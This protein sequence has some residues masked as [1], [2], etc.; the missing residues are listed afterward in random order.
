MTRIEWP[1]LARTLAWILAAAFVL[2]SVLLL[3]FALE[4]FG[5]PPE[6]GAEFLDNVLADFAWQQTQWPIEFAGTALFAIGFLALGGLGPV[7]GRLARSADARRGIVAAAFLTAGGLGAAS[8][9][10]WIG[11]KPIATS[12]QYCECGLL[13]EELMSRLMTLNIVTGIQTWLVS[14]ALLA[15][16]VGLVAAG[17]LGREAGMPAS[18]EWL[19]LATAVAALMGVVLPLFDVYPFDVLFVVLVAGILVPIWA[20]WLGARAA[21]IWPQAAGERSEPT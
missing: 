18:W 14:G 13:A 15:A 19:A 20:V 7:L 2:A 1:T 3:I 5:G 21:E 8:Q 4:L 10:L 12:A 9:L 17:R 11:A 6:P 16:A